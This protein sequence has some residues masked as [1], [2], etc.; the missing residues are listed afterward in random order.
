M[1]DIKALHM[2]ASSCKQNWKSTGEK[3]KIQ[4]RLAELIHNMQ[5]TKSSLKGDIIWAL[6][7]ISAHSR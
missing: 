7:G 3:L 6:L 4:S 5:V 1:Q 2:T